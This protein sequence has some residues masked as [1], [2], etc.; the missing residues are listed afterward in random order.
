M[1]FFA[2]YFKIKENEAVYE[3]KHLGSNMISINDAVEITEDTLSTSI[4][5]MK[6]VQSYI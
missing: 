6:R 5:A 1:S 3:L 2:F 4:T